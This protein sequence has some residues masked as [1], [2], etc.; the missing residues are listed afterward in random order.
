MTA[1]IQQISSGIDEQADAM[2]E[3]ARRA[4]V[5]SEMGEDTYERVDAFKLNAHEAADL[6]EEV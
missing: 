3:V 4:Q 2:D 1:S 6:T 5:L